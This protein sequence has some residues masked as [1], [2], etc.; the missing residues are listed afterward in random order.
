[1]SEI[2]AIGV[3]A[4]SLL[5]TR[6]SPSLHNLHMPLHLEAVNSTVAQSSME[7]HVVSKADN[8][9]HA[10][11]ALDTFHDEGHSLAPSSVRVWPLLI[12]LT[13]NNLSYARG[14]DFLHWCV[15]LFAF[16]PGLSIVF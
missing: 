2:G 1:M 7:V 11:A 13:S 10:V 3:I 4:Y 6:P 14:G 12:A 9:K 8:Q 5:R 15:I 16:F